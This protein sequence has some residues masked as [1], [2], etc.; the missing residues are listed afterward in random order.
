MDKALEEVDKQYALGEK[1][2]DVPAM[3]GD[4]QLKGNIMLEMGKPDE[5]KALFERGLKMTEGSTL[6]SGDQGQRATVS[7]LQSGSRGSRQE[8]RGDRE[9]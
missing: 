9:D 5:A 1:T 3:T 6:V 4:L 2:N 8:R 7:S